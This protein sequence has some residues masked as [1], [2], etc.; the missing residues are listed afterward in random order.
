MDLDKV[1]SIDCAND[2]SL[3]TVFDNYYH[4]LCFYA[5]RYLKNDDEI[6]DIVQ[7]V[8]V[9]LWE[10]KLFFENKYALKTFLYSS[11]YHAV[12][13]KIKQTEIY[14]RHHG[15][16]L[17]SGDE[18]DSRNYLT[19]RIEDEALL[20]IYQAIRQLPPK[21]REIFMLSYIQGYDIDQVAQKMNIS[22]H[23][24]KSQRARAK[25]LLQNYLKDLFVLFLASNSADL[26]D[27]FTDTLK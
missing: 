13:N 20:S 8:F 2:L 25:K 16:I 5:G 24:V 18:A 23:T 22:L 14:R 21:C 3:Q 19:E 4:S 11:V 1:N 17:Y 9:V 26:F 27:V 15:N 7:E 10:K 12:L 6:K